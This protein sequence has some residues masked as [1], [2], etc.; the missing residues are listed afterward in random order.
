V[1]RLAVEDFTQVSERTM[2]A[3]EPAF[4]SDDLNLIVVFYMTRAT[5]ASAEQ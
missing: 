4:R 2:W 3:V 1:S 5:L